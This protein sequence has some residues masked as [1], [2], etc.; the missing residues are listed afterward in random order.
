M[1]LYRTGI[2]VPPLNGN[3]TLDVL[4]YADSHLPQ[5]GISGNRL[6]ISVFKCKVYSN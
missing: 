4:W 6:A 3:I 2:N 5:I 1:V